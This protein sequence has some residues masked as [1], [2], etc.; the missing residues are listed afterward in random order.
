MALNV[1]SLKN[2]LEVQSEENIKKLL[3]SFETISMKAE[4]EVDDVCGFLHNKAIQYEKMDLSRT[5]IVF[6][7]Y[8]SKPFIA[9]YFSIANKPLTI[10]KKHFSKFSGSLRKRL[11][12]FGNKTEQ[13]NYIVTG[14]LLGQLGKNFSKIALMANALT[15]DQLLELAYRQI[16]IVYEITGGRILYLE[17]EEN[18]KL[19]DF[20]KRNGFTQLLDF[21]TS[22]N[23][24]IMV[25][26]LK[27]I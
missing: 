3:F 1:V 9:G 24:C 27:D 5:F 22:N 16:R 6:S 13:D 11:L 19:L 12:G 21:K 26:N 17:Y 2:L 20:Y 23:L 8:Q 7:T 10:S 18:S 25:K 15:G 4:N 14:L